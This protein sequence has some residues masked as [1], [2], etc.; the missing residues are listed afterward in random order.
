L[1]ALTNPVLKEQ[2]MELEFPR[3]VCKQLPLAEAVLRLGQ[4]VLS[5]ERLNDIYQRRRGASY[6]KVITFP[7]FVNLIGDA[8]LE[9]DGKGHQAFVRAIEK[10]QLEASKQ[11]AYGK[12]HRVPISLS[13]G[14]LADT[15]TCLQSVFPA[16][17]A[18]PVPASLKGMAVINIDGK[19]L[20]HLPKRLL[21]LRHLKGKLY[22]GKLVV[23]ADQRTGLTLAMEAVLDGETSD[24]P[25]V[26]GLLKQLRQQVAKPRLYVEDRQ[27]RD[28]VQPG[29]L[30]ENE[31][32]LIRYH[33]KVGFHRDEGKSVRTGRTAEG[34]LWEEE[35]GWLG[36]PAD[37]RRVR[38]RRITLSR[39]GEEAVI[40][41]TDLLDATAYPAGDLLKVY[42]HRWDI[43]QLFQRVT[44][45]FSLRELISSTPR[46][47][48]FQAAYCFLLSN[49]VITIRAFLAESQALEPEA[50]STYQVHYD[51][52]RE[53]IAWNKM[54]DES[55]T[56][57]VLAKPL[58]AARLRSHLARRLK[59]AWTNRWLKTPP[60]KHTP[61]ERKIYIR[62]GHTSVQ[63][64][65]MKAKGT[66]KRC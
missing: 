59:S 9:H 57:N 19:K 33:P 55:A 60:S 5:E 51:L 66:K 14:F 49:M 37:P 30:E 17:V 47:T 11:A 23:A 4:L 1:L 16:T 65:L 42:R 29:L 34:G 27:F 7:L 35:W 36:K 15:S 13:T 38:V 50:I 56:L 31:H 8:L 10:G 40:V 26:P 18:S 48:I 44:E 43:E 54:L 21:P 64:L 46:A 39:E 24:A 2:A 62:G 6:E 32:F 28:L 20:K 52:Q 45:V 22:G 25:L 12:L 61:V 58:S 3:E 63:R 53:L 41:V